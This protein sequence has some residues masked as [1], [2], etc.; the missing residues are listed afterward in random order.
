MSTVLHHSF[1]LLPHCYSW[2]DTIECLSRLIYA[3]LFLALCLRVARHRALSMPYLPCTKMPPGLPAV[4]CPT[5]H[6]EMR[7]IWILPADKPF[8]GHGLTGIE[9]AL[10]FAEFHVRYPLGGFYHVWGRWLA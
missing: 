4:T 10:A 3:A 6:Y 2:L 7:C 1:V 9:R 8:H 5:P